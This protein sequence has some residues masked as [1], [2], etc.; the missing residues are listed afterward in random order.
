MR[1]SLEPVRFVHEDLGRQVWLRN[2]R[3]NPSIRPDIELTNP[4]RTA[5]HLLEG[6]PI[7]RHSSEVLFAVILHRR[8]H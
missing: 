8:E 7:D 2:H 3:R 6:A 4:A 1:D 5:D